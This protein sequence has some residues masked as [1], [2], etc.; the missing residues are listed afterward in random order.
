MRRALK[1]MALLMGL[2]MPGAAHAGPYED[3][4]AAYRQG[5]YAQA[6]KWY[7]LAA[8]QGDADAQFNLGF[9]YASGQGV[10]KD[11]VLAYMWR[12]LAAAAA[13]DADIRE[14][15]AKAREALAR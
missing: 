9:M 14:Q 15:A 2:L 3:A 7:R 10:P 12:N 5:D 8:D 6:V 4:S 13:S 1:V 11:Y